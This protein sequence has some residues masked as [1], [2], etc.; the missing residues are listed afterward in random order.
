MLNNNRISYREKYHDL[1]EKWSI[2]KAKTMELLDRYLLKLVDEL[3]SEEPFNIN[4][5]F[6][7]YRTK[8]EYIYDLLEGMLIEELVCLW[9]SEQGCNA[10]RVGCDANG[11]IIRGGQRR[12]TTEPDIVVDG[13]YIEIQVSRKGILNKYYIKKNKGD[14]ILAGQNKLMFVVDD[15]YFLI[16]AKDIDKSTLRVAYVLGGKEAYVV[17]PTESDYK[18][19][20]DGNVCEILK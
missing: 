5:Y 14:R 9:F 2:D 18:R 17:K 10:K 15:K 4:G 6:K 11:K 8:D 20:K 3:C 1:P 13:N 16:G 19:F 7:D 12:I